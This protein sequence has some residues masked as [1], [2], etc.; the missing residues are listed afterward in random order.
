MV[1]VS[2][3]LTRIYAAILCVV[4]SASAALAQ[5]WAVEELR[6]HMSDENSVKAAP[7]YMPR[8]VNRVSAI[9]MVISS[10]S[11]NSWVRGYYVSQLARSGIAV[12][13]L[14]DLKPLDLRNVI[15]SV[16]LRQLEMEAFYAIAELQKDRRIDPARVS[17]MEISDESLDATSLARRSMRQINTISFAINTAVRSVCDD[18]LTNVSSPGELNYGMTNP[19]SL[20]P[21]RFC[22]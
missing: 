13:I 21:F 5:S 1:P 4:I 7:L 8:A 22:F 18:R 20:K 15:E 19:E 6:F 2:K 10:S 14:D 12:L 11:V 3:I 9:V 17:V 16:D